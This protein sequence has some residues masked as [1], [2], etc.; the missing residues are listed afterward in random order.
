ML[1]FSLKMQNLM[2][3]QNS[4]FSPSNIWLSET[5]ASLFHSYIIF[6]FITLAAAPVEVV[7]G[8]WEFVKKEGG[9]VW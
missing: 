3:I 6:F 9:V 8:K 1:Q 2:E 5:S 4:V 7:C